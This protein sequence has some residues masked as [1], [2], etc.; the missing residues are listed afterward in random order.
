MTGN[1]F[2]NA[3]DLHLSP[4]FIQSGNS[5]GNMFVYDYVHMYVLQAISCEYIHAS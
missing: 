2:F 5:Q 3:P 1:D 4:I